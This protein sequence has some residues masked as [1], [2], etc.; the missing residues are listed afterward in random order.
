[1]P[2]PGRRVLQIEP[3][4]KELAGGVVAELLDVKVDAGLVG[5]V[6][7]LVGDPVRVPRA[8]VQRVVGEQVGVLDQL[9]AD[10]GEA[11]ADSLGRLADEGAADRVQREPPVLVGLGVLADLL[12]ALD[13]VVEGDV[14]GAVLQLEVAELDRAQLAAARAGDRRKPDVEREQQPVRGPGLGDDLSHV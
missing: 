6:A 13:E 1:V 14:H 8:R 10:R 4:G 7:D 9:Q 3:G 2:Q 12:A 11:R 5:Q